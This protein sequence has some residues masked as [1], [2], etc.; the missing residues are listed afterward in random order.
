MSEIFSFYKDLLTTNGYQI[1]RGFVSTGRTQS[2][3]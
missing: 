2:G 3:I 1:N